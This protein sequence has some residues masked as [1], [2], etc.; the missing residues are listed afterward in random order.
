MP[1]WKPPLFLIPQKSP[2]LVW[3]LS[4]QMSQIVTHV[5]LTTELQHYFFIIIS[6]Q[7]NIFFIFLTFEDYLPNFFEEFFTYVLF[8]STLLQL[9]VRNWVVLME[10]AGHMMLLL[11]STKMYIVLVIGSLVQKLANN[12][13]LACCQYSAT[14]KNNFSNIPAIKHVWWVVVDRKK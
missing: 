13:N 14:N 3:S 8:I 11:F 10:F 2:A 12:F 9:I 1:R 6:A 5:W 7:L 4:A